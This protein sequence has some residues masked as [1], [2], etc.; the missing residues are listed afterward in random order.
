MEVFGLLNYM[1]MPKLCPRDGRHTPRQNKFQELHY[2]LE[3]GMEQL[4]SSV[5][6]VMLW[7][8]VASRLVRLGKM[9][10]DLRYQLSFLAPM[11]P[12]HLG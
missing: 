5:R 10:N 1:Q 12:C 6:S 7:N 11:S 3:F 4:T 2:I 9:W 8:E